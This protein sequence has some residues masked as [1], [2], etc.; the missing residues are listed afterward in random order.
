[1][2]R[3]VMPRWKFGGGDAGGSVEVWDP[4][5]EYSALYS[6]RVPALTYSHVR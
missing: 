5:H 6:F 4:A 3:F 2:F 1:M